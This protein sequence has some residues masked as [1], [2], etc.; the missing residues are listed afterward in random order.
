MAMALFEHQVR[1][2]SATTE[3]V[4]QLDAGFFPAR[5]RLARWSFQPAIYAHGNHAGPTTPPV[6]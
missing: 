2:S 1:G 6:D 5:H 3:G 4:G